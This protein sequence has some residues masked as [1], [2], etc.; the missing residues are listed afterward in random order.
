MTYFDKLFNELSKD[1]NICKTINDYYK[2][3]TL[4]NNIQKVID[5]V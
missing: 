3:K 5:R 4:D 1:Y 2:K